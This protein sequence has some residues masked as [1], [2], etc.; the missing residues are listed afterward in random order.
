[1]HTD[2]LQRSVGIG[3]PLIWGFLLTLA[4]L[5]GLIAFVPLPMMKGAPDLVKASLALSLTIAMFP[6]WPRVE[7]SP[8]ISTI[9]LWTAG[10]AALGIG[11]GLTVA[12]AAEGIAIATQ[13]IATQAGYSYATSVDP[14]SSADSGVLPILGQLMASLLFFAFGLDRQLISILVRSLTTLP[15]DGPFALLNGASAEALIRLGAGAFSTGLRLAL[16]VAAL[17]IILDISLAL[18][19]RINQ[20]LQLLSVAFPAKML[21]TLGVLAAIAPVIARVYESQAIDALRSL[22]R[23]VR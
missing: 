4:R 21:L 5:G 8:E 6:F 3:L 17:L 10:E 11:M 2:I 9:L 18:V 19:G 23:M 7:G 15:P 16:P 20:Q 22:S 12:F 1:M 13:L 14:N